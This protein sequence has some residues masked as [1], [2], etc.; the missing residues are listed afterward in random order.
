MNKKALLTILIFTLVG[1]GIFSIQLSKKNRPL[2]LST[3][4]NGGDLSL[5]TKD[6]FFK[7]TDYRG[8]ILVLYFGYTFCPDI[9]PTT[10]A[11]ISTTL[12]KLAPEKAQQIQPVFISID[13]ERDSFEKLEEYSRFFHPKIIS[14]SDTPSK[15]KRAAN[16]YGVSYKKHFPKKGDPFYVV[17]HST[18]AFIVDKNGKLVELIPHGTTPTEI[19]NKLEKYFLSESL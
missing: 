18:Q 10:L 14:A 16:L 5:K 4:P 7:S 19:I 9:C 11:T 2:E 8:K 13:P 17:D 12:K 6:G 1:L 3:F 15:L